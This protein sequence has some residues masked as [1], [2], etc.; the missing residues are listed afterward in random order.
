MDIENIITVCYNASG[1]NFKLAEDAVM[2]GIT[3]IHRILVFVFCIAVTSMGM[4]AQNRSIDFPFSYSN[5]ACTLS[6]SFGNMKSLDVSDKI[7]GI[8]TDET[9]SDRLFEENNALPYRLHSSEHLFSETIL[10]FIPLI[11]WFVFAA[12]LQNEFV[13]R[14][15]LILFIHNSDGKKGVLQAF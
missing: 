14:M 3:S 9:K 11:A 8:V 5:T 4:Y 13:D 7:L 1:L 6:A 2:K 10:P 15:Y 12:F